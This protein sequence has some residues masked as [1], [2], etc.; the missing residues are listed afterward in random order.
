MREH[1]KAIFHSYAEIFFLKG[2]RTGALLFIMTLINPNVAVAGIIA[3]VSAYLFARFINMDREFLKS[4][5][6]T[7]NPL[8]VGLSI[9]YLFQ[10]TPLTIFFIVVAGISAFVLTVMLFNIFWYY[11]KL[12]VLSIP[13]VVIS[14]VAYLASSQYANLFVSGLYPHFTSQVELYLPLWINGLLKSLGVILFM[15]DAVVGFFFLIAIFLSSRILFMLVIIGYYTGTLLNALLIGSFLQAF[16]DINSFNFILIAI[17]LG[18][19][20]FIPSP[21]SYALALI[22]VGTSTILLKSV[23]VFWATYGIPAFTLPFNVVSLSFIYVL[24]IVN[25]PLIARYIRDTPEETLDDY[26]TNIQR[27]PGTLRTLALPFSGKWQVWQGFDGKWTH[28]GSWRYA[29][30]FVVV[31]EAGSTFKNAG[32]TLEDYYAFRKPVLSPVRGRVV[33]VINS[34]ADMPIGEVDRSNNWGNLLI[35]YDPRGFFVEISHFARSSIKVSE[36]DWVETGTFLGL[37]GNSGYSPQPHI[38]VQVQATGEIGAATLPFSFT[39]Y[40]AGEQFF[41]NDLPKEGEQVE[42]LFAERALDIK[43]T[44]ILDQVITYEIYREGQKIDELTLTVRMAPDG[45]F[46]FD[47]GNGRL[48]LGK[49]EGTFYFYRTEGSNPY[50]R[51]MMLA[52][53]RL[54][55][56]YRQGMS[57]QDY[58]PV[59]TIT[60]GVRK[61][62]ALFF[63]SFRHRLNQINFRGQFIAEGIVE[64]EIYSRF[65]NVSGKTRV[66]LDEFAGFKSIRVNNVEL[67]KKKDEKND[68]N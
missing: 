39:S 9:G 62:L 10:I 25:Y 61:A 47:S 28:Q 1:L 35:I 60:S 51:R 63:G 19:I 18:G 21:K 64:G 12:P 57:W 66:E 30:D 17:A 24:G 27:F 53:P 15:P 58:V 8:L 48:Y 50:L 4:G 31:D 6:Y 45:T 7:Y 42:P 33:K 55:L 46:Y 67:R 32:S 13:F 3:V 34:L 65:L 56:A 38:H 52:L 11:L 20:F 14:S 49:H 68:E 22:G 40:L 43:L 23:E 29:Y 37:C 5:F 36:G 26:L 41:A 44:F 2:M 16:S 59:G 54:P